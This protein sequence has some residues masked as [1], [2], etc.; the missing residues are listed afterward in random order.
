M[1]SAEAVFSFSLWFSQERFPLSWGNCWLANMQDLNN[2]VALKPRLK[3]LLLK[4]TLACMLC[5][6]TNVLL[7]SSWLLKNTVFKFQ[8]SMIK[9]DLFVDKVLT[10]EYLP[11]ST[12]TVLN[13]T[14][15][16]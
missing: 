16:S 2:V 8:V 10:T 5:L 13:N 7:K 15:Q 6:P 1:C 11:V 4:N 3:P 12:K 9:D 14:S